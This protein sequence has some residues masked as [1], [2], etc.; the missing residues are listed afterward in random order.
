M[1]EIITALKEA[2]DNCADTVDK[3]TLDK[4]DCIIQQLED[5]ERIKSKDII[6]YVTQA[7]YLLK[8]LAGFIE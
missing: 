5:K 7:Y 8:L 4:L 1:K 2:R 6:Q 3:S